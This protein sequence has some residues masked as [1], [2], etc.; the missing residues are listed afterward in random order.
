MVLDDLIELLEWF[1]RERVVLNGI[2]N[3][4]SWRG[5]YNELAFEPIGKT[6]VGD[7]LDAATSA[8]GA[9]FEGWKGGEYKMDGGTTIHIEHEGNYSDNDTALK[10][11]FDLMIGHSDD[12][13][14]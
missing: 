3:P 2:G 7:I 9:T 8:H 14:G 13:L 6:S 11:L 5:D 4:H 1:P 12:S 10:M